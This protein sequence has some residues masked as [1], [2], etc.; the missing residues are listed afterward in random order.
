MK[1]SSWDSG[2]GKVP[3]WS[4]GFWVPMTKKGFFSGWVSPST[5]ICC[6]SIAS[7]SALWVFGVA[8]FI[9]SASTQWAKMGPGWK[10]KR[11]LAG[12]KMDTPRISAGNR[13]LVN[14]MRLKSRPNTA[15]MAWASVVLPTP[16]RSSINK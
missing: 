5:V 9:S 7:S 3:A 16:G 4:S 14:W 2:S 10:L 15:A 6:S 13:S 12:S 8:R 1:R 11:W